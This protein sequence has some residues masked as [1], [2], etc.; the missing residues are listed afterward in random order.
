METLVVEMRHLRFHG[1]ALGVIGGGDEVAV[2]V[3]N[4]Y[5]ELAPMV[6]GAAYSIE[7]V[8]LAYVEV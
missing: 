7:I 1:Y 8:G 4:N 5:V 2:Y 3:G 6:F